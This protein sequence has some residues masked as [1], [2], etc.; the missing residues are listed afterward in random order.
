MCLLFVVM[1]S[2]APFNIVVDLS[3]PFEAVVNEH[4]S[5]PWYLQDIKLPVHSD[6]RP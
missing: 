3:K 6:R 1:R 4:L 2:L 5:E